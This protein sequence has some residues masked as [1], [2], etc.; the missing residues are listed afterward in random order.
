MRRHQ[1]PKIGFACPPFDL[2]QEAG[3]RGVRDEALLIL[4]QLDIK[5]RGLVR[6]PQDLVAERVPDKGRN[7]CH[8]GNGD[9]R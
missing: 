7:A 8:G 5:H 6:M 1:Q 2:V 3:H 4:Y 9:D